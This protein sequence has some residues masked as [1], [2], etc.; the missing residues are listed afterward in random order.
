MAMSNYLR[1]TVMDR[2]NDIKTEYGITEISYKVADDETIYPHI[3]VDIPSITPTDMGREDFLLDIHIWTQNN[4]QAFEIADAVRNLFAFYNAPDENILPVFYE[5][6]GGQVDD[7]DKKICH[8]VLR[9]QGQVY[10]D[11]VTDAGILGKE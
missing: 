6:S 1:K 2:L 4:Y 3:V 5:L 10:E 9:I 7:P 8:H 11:G